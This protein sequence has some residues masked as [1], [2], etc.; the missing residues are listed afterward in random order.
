MN[1][2]I[3]LNGDGY[4]FIIRGYQGV[5]L[6]VDCSDTATVGLILPIWMNTEIMLN[7][8]G[9]CLLTVGENMENHGGIIWHDSLCRHGISYCHDP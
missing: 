5:I 4:V 6:G 7:G 2:E 9:M 1:T 3:M 8:T